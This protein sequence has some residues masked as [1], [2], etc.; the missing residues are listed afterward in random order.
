MNDKEILFARR[1]AFLI[2]TCLVCM[3]VLVD[4]EEARL[5]IFAMLGVTWLADTILLKRCK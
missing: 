4:S 3:L 2:G 5:M 1:C